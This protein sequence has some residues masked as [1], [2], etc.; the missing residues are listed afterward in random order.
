MICNNTSK[1]DFFFLL[2]RCFKTDYGIFC[3]LSIYLR[4]RF[5]LQA[6]KQNCGSYWWRHKI[7][8]N[9]YLFFTPLPRKSYEKW[10]MFSISTYL[11]TEFWESSVYYRSLDVPTFMLVH[12]DLIWLRSHLW[13][14][15][16]T[17]NTFNTPTVFPLVTPK[18]TPT[19]WVFFPQN[20][21]F[22]FV[23]GLVFPCFRPIYQ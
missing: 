14:H 23:S 19:P 6:P 5:V 9:N 8:K 22:L 20:L 2:A 11:L 18:A 3:G 4:V 16:I 15:V 10:G 17:A 21:R 1:D 7:H 13:N 12:L